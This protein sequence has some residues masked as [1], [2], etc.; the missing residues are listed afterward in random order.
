MRLQ[1]E[2]MAAAKQK[3]AA[4]A[5][6]ATDRIVVLSN[7][8]DQRPLAQKVLTIQAKEAEAE[9]SLASGVQEKAIANMND[10]V[11]IEDAIYALAQPP[12]P[13]IRIH[14]LYGTML[15]EMNRPAQAQKQLDD[16]LERT[17]GRPRAIYG[18]A[19]D[20]RRQWATIRGQSKIKPPLG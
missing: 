18:L 1:I 9:A 4:A 2:A 12:Y 14:E 15:L 16:C 6:A 20:L 13:P 10:A 8:A 5:R 7:E 3:D 19:S 11:R 17:P